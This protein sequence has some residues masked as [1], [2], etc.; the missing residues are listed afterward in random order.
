MY[1][2]LAFDAYEH[3][4]PAGK[5]EGYLPL[6][7]NCR[8]LEIGIGNLKL[9]KALQARG[10]D[11]HGIDVSR[12]IVDAGKAAGL[13]ELHL[14]DVSEAPLPYDDDSFDAIYC[15][16]VF[17]HLTN[18]HRLFYEIRRTLKR[19]EILY[20]SVPCQEVDMGYGKF[21]HPFIYP[22]LLIKEHLERFF[23]Q[24]DFRIESVVEPEG[25]LVGRSYMLRNRKSPS[26]PDIV[27]VVPADY[28]V[29]VLYGDVLTPEQL[30]REL[31]RETGEYL[32]ILREEAGRQNWQGVSEVFGVLTEQYSNHYPIYVELVSILSDHGRS[33]TA[34]RVCDSVLSREDVPLRILDKIRSLRDALTP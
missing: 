12:S 22:G 3:Y 29:Q 23:M 27:E 1:S 4:Q 9:L 24:M 28:T 30:E 19:D 20:F 7:E 17:E 13:G 8:V 5:D 11:I 15:Y 25:R 10:N 14:L 34:R 31:D 2:N 33:D 26:R 18:P 6:V 32:R 16:E 21:R